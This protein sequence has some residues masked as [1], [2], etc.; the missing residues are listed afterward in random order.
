MTPSNTTPKKEFNYADGVSLKEYI[1]SRLKAIEKAIELAQAANNIRLDT[2]NEFRGSLTDQASTFVSRQELSL[3]LA[4]L[5]SEIKD[6]KNRDSIS[7]IEYDTNHKVLEGKIDVL[8][9][10]K[11][12]M[13]GKASQSSVNI[14]YVISG[15]G[16]I[17][18]LV[19]LL[20]SLFG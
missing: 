8:N 3:T 20:H 12:T 5:E 11:D 6:L 14:A 2:M 13:T 4:K 9:T 1:E 18:G 10:Y 17:I 15:I 16:I 19:G 7:R